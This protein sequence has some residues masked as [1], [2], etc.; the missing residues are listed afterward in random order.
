MSI[1][2]KEVNMKIN[3]IHLQSLSFRLLGLVFVEVDRAP[4][5]DGQNPPALAVLV[6]RAHKLCEEAAETD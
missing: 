5:A 3:E 4:V 6:R 2:Q 1:Y